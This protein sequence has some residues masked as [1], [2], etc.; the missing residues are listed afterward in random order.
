MAIPSWGKSLASDP[1]LIAQ[2]RV[3][4]NAPC[5]ATTVV[6]APCCGRHCTADSVADVREVSGTV[7]NGKDQAFLCEGCRT[8]LERNASAGWSRSRLM[9]LRGA[10]VALVHRIRARELAHAKRREDFAARRPHEEMTARAEA[11][12]QLAAEHLQAIEASV[13][14]SHTELLPEPAA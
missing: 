2:Y 13:T 7:V 4:A 9:E 5:V 3:K 6:R 11:A 1:L 12:M 10:P 8:R 14:D